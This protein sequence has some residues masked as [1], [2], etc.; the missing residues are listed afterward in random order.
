MGLFPIYPANRKLVKPATRLSPDGSTFPKS[1]EGL[2][3]YAISS[4]DPT[5]KNIPRVS[6]DSRSKVLS[7]PCEQAIEH[8]Q[9]SDH[10]NLFRSL[11][12]VPDAKNNP[13]RE[14]GDYRAASQS[15]K[16]FLQI[17]PIDDFFTDSG[18]DGYAHPKENLESRLRQE[19]VN[20]LGEV[21]P[22]E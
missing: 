17:A 5:A 9:Y 7:P 20:F 14:N 1:E 16:L 21:G 10:H 4:R 6:D 13:L 12:R 19:D 8:A 15:Q 2:I 18:R 22:H 3:I 11:I